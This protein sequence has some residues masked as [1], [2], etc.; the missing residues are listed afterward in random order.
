[1][2]NTFS[3]S[4]LYAEWIYGGGTVVLSGQQRSVQLTPSINLHNATAGDDADED[5]LTGTKDATI[6]YAG[7]MP[8][9]GDDPSYIDVEDALV[10]GT[11][12]TLIFGPEGTATGKRKYTIPAISQG[13][14]MNFP[15]NDIVEISNEFQKSGSPLARAT[16]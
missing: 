1:M 7:V 15:Y 10:E 11:S 4:A 6:S 13:P 2:A 16:Y 8:K 12:G 9:V 5:Y 14:Q 3:G